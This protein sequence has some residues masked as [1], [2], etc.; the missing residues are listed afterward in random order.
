VLSNGDIFKGHWQADKPHGKGALVSI[1]HRDVFEGEV[2]PPPKD[3]ASARA[4][5]TGEVLAGPEGLVWATG[6]WSLLNGWRVEASRWRKPRVPQEFVTITTPP[7][8]AHR[9]ARTTVEAFYRVYG[10]VS[11]RDDADVRVTTGPGVELKDRTIFR[12]Q[13]YPTPEAEGFFVVPKKRMGLLYEGERRGSMVDAA[14]LEDGAE[15]DV[16][17]GLERKEDGTTE[18]TG[19]CSK[20]HPKMCDRWFYTVYVPAAVRCT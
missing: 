18:Y 10:D 12:G 15:E 1:A 6:K 17:F 11:R 2:G 19:K 4:S 20:T 8:A 7:D 13:V 3:G 5:P 9:G 16:V 14:W